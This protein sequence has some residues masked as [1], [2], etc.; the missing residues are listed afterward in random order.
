MIGSPGQ[1]NYAAANTFLD[2]LAAHR[3]AQGLPARLDRLGAWAASGMTGRAAGRSRRAWPRM[4][5]RLGLAPLRRAGPG[6]VR[7]RPRCRA[8]AG[9]GSA[10]HA[11]LRSGQQADAAGGARAGRRLRA[12]R[13][14]RLACGAPCGRPEAERERPLLDLVRGHVAAVLGHLGGRGRAGTAFQDLGFD[15][16]AAVEL[17][18]RLVTATG[19]RLPATLVFDYPTPRLAGGA[20]ADL[21]SGRQALPSVARRCDRRRRADRDRRH[22]LPLPRRG[23]SPEEL[24]SWSRGGGDAIS[25]FPE[26]RGWDLDGSTTPTPTGRAPAMSARGASSTTR[27]SFDADF[28]G[29][30]PREALMD[31]QQRLLLETCWEPWSAPGIDPALPARQRHRCLRRGHVPGLRD[32]REPSGLGATYGYAAASSPGGSPT[33]SDSRAPR[34]PST[35][36]AAPRWSPCTWPARRCAGGSASSRWPAASP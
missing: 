24:G 13:R 35:P 31:P 3:R 2:A 19:L 16:L 23:R 5:Q 12:E 26:D 20:P 15:S 14:P 32:R 28:F 27:P 11:V 29:I 18:N 34:S 9:P 10:R 36:P 8:A 6:P 1:A 30:S 22:G 33:P 7:R 21:A 25:G 4:R 17:R